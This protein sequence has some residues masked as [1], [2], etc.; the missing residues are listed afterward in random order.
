MKRI[1]SGLIIFCTV[2][3]V[4]IP[5]TAQEYSEQE[6][7]VAVTAL[8]RINTDP[9][10]MEVNEEILRA[11]I[12]SPFV[13][14]PHRRESI[15]EVNVIYLSGKDNHRWFQLYLECP[16]SIAFTDESTAIMNGIA[17][18]L[19]MVLNNEFEA[20]KERLVM[21]L[22]NAEL[23]YH[24][25]R[26]NMDELRERENALRR[27]AGNGDLSREHILEK[28]RN[29][30]NHKQELE[31]NL[32][33]MRA[34]REALQRQI[35][36]CADQFHERLANDPVIKELED[37]MERQTSHLAET[38][39]MV[40]EGQLAR[41]EL[42]ELHDELARSRMALAERREMIRMQT[43]GES[44]ERWNE[45][46]VNISMQL[47]G[48]EVQLNFIREKM[49]EIKAKDLLALATQYETEIGI[50]LDLAYSILKRSAEQ[51]ERVRDQLET[52]RPPSIQILG[53]EPKEQ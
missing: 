52:L 21:Q 29:M 38:E 43:G 42:N 22:Q 2:L 18:K 12:N 46:L 28:I 15:G 5:A 14:E 8:L 39:R 13:L 10:V 34:R 33:G 16:K 26:R 27:Q 20:Y 11:L 23:K 41:Q 1:I 40:K 30:D 36:K 49:E 35:E 50:N 37:I 31:M 4:S 51:R 45:E 48:N 7:T 3:F 32:I 24:N 9:V 19:Q 47:T 6:E 17:N 25:A 53:S 44:L